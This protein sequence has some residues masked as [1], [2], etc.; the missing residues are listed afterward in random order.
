MKMPVEFSRGLEGV[1]AARS[2]LSKVDGEKGRLLYVGYPIEDLARY[3]TFEEV[4]FLLWYRRL[5]KKDELEE[6][7]RKMRQNRDLPKP[8]V[9]LIRKLPRNMHPMDALRTVVSF[10]SAFDEELEVHTPEANL[11]KSIR[12]TA[13]M[14][15]I[16]AYFDRIRSGLKP[17]K[18]DPSLSHAANFLWMMHGKKPS[19]LEART[20]DVS[21]ILHADHGMNAST[22]ANLVT[23]STLSDM[24]SAVCTGIA[25]L[26]GPLH[27]GANEQVVKMLQQIGSLENVEP[28][29]NDALAKKYKIMGFGHRVYKAYDPRCTILKE[30]ARKLSEYRNNWTF[31]QMG[32]KIESLLIP[33]LGQ[34]NVYP[35]VDFYSGIVYYHLNIPVDMYTPIFAMSRVSGWTA[36][37]MEYLE[38][39]RI[40]RPLDDYVG[41]E[42]RPYVPIDQR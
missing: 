23:I 7:D 33:K 24:Y 17:V 13:K 8:A 3:S 36:R 26:K 9:E 37:A 5:P 15:T 19:E 10:L 20:M 18:P 39:N 2:I 28:W 1:Y 32:D 29:L 42:E 16:G 30:Y 6:L 11:N 35:N 12:L 22:F 14:T 38:D 27:G 41:P 25:T 40:F 31:Y 4:C 34:K 21:F